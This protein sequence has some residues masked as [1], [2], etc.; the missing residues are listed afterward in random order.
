MLAHL[1]HAHA[2]PAGSLAEALLAAGHTSLSG[3]L[4]A[5]PA[6]LAA[7]AAAAAVPTEVRAA[8]APGQGSG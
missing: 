4:T 3:V 7:A 2:L 6:A 1:G 8:L 5:P